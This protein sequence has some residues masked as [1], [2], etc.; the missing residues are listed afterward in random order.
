MFNSSNTSGVIHPPQSLWRG[1][2]L[3]SR[4]SVSSPESRSP[5]AQ[6]DP[7]GPP[8]TIKTSQ[9]SIIRRLPYLGP[10]WCRCTGGCASMERTDI[11]LLYT[12]DAADEEDSV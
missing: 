3:R 2:A 1:K 4:M 9:E 5:Q 10:D 11:C 8:P 12:S 6:E 7:A